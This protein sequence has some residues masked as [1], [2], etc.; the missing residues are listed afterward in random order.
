MHI[1]RHVSSARTRWM[2]GY[3][4]RFLAGLFAFMLA[5]SSCYA[6]S[7]L[8]PE[9]RRDYE[10]RPGVVQVNITL[11]GKFRNISC[12]SGWG[13]TGFLY[14][15]DGYLVTNGHVVQ[16]A[17]TK[18]S[19]AIN[20]RK[21]AILKACLLE[22]IHNAM[23]V[24]LNERDVA[25]IVNEM[26][27]QSALVVILDNNAQYE[28]EIKAY[29][30][31]ITS[32]GKDIAV[33]KIDANNLPT[34]P[35]G[36][37]DAMNVNDR[38]YVIGYPGDAEISDASVRVA[39]SSDGIISAVK[40]KDYSGTPLLQTNANINHGN[41]GGPAFDSAGRVI[42]ISTLGSKAP[43]F[44]FL[45]PISTA[46]EFIRQAGAEPERGSFDKTWHDALD[47]FSDQEW[48]KAHTLLGE[49]LEMMP[50]QPEAQKLQMEAMA[51]VPTES[52]WQKIKE[53]RQLV[54]ISVAA[55]ALIGLAMIVLLLMR[56]KKPA[57][58]PGASPVGAKVQ[59]VVVNASPASTVLEGAAKPLPAPA[60]TQSFGE[61]QAS[62]GPL[63]GNRFPIPKA[64]LL[65]GRDPTKCNVV[66]SEDS[67]GKEHAWVV[68]LDN[69]VAVIDR[70]STNGTY[71]NATN[72]PRINKV[73]LRHGD[74]IYLGKTSGT[75]F[76][77]YSV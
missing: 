26:S 37:S 6:Q 61:L 41:S 68:P 64:G 50:N 74:R 76:T 3:V 25:I 18:D 55:V 58:I 30:D 32:G 1:S 28:G 43:G 11:L 69:G 13:G 59:A 33:I 77:Y 38:V 22:K 36:D 8:T 42:G 14:R 56:S 51:N 57:G 5:G 45:V 75:V 7:T 67:V 31:P 71:V 70:N 19:D 2:N 52:L 20:A 48:S 16:F 34:V 62:G 17:N 9:A 72:S 4:V 40:V 60:P 10:L 44:N 27:V 73:V 21:V 54:L 46:K 15:P 53:M 24:N 49:V 39:T 66:V 65:I 29:S 63:T 35:L 23:R 12:K 47:A